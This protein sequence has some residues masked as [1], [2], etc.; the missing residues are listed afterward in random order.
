MIKAL[1]LEWQK[2]P[3]WLQN[4]LLVL[5]SS[6]LLGLFAHFAIPLQPVPIATQPTL[7]LLLGVLL[8]SKRAP[9]AVAAFLAQGAIGLPVFANGLAGPAVLFGPRGGYLFGYLIAAYLVGKIT[10]RFPNKKL[11]TA[12]LAMVAGNIVLYI[13]GA[14]WL[15]TFLGPQKAIALGV[16]PFVFFDL[17]KIVASIQFLRWRGWS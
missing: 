5:G 2:A 10:E 1:S 8:G 14:S 16:A 13:M 11:L 12:F 3:A 9:A 7:V 15:S 17:V 6:I 4:T